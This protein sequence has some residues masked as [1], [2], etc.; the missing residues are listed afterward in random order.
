SFEPQPMLEL[1]RNVRETM[2]SSGLTE[3]VTYPLTKGNLTHAVEGNLPPLR[4]ANPLSSEMEE[5]RV[6]LQAGILKTLSANQQGSD[7]VRLFELGRVYRPQPQGLPDECEV[8]AAV[9]SGTR[10]EPFWQ[11]GS[12][13]L[14][15]FDG[16]GVLDTLFETLGVAVAYAPSK[17]Q[18]LHPSRT[19][20][21]SINRTEIGVIGELDPTHLEAL[22]LLSR[23]VVYMEVDLRLL[24]T[25]LPD[26]PHMYHAIPRFPGLNRD[27]ALIVNKDVP[28]D[29]VM[30]L[31]RAA[32]LV[33][34]A[35]LFDIY[36]GEQVPVGKKSFALRLMY[37]SPG[38]T[39]TNAEADK[40]Q[41]RLLSQLEQ[42]LGATL[43]ESIL[44][45]GADKIED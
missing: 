19:A 10:D 24:L 26:R 28:V 23:S 14:D 34:R 9:L 39:L 32:P 38:R 18:L 6:S 35:D 3:I 17:Q 21:I 36:S 44:Q 43:R 15:F 42:E 45:S 33:Q 31:I 25:H 20:V 1:K 13:N 12:G 29:K 16:K 37:Q 7:S 22:N 41:R 4:V 8:L 27:L 5:L 40:T 11:K 30:R 2:V